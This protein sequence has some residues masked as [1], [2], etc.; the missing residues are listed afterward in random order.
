MYNTIKKCKKCNWSIKYD[1]N[2][3]IFNKSK[4]KICPQCGNK[5]IKKP[6]SPNL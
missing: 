6:Y 3:D 5:L 1:S 2:N 4:Y